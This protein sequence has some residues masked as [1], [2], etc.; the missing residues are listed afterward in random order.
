MS[1]AIL[2]SLDRDGTHQADLVG[3]DIMGAGTT[4]TSC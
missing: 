2:H 4:I 1:K 3:V